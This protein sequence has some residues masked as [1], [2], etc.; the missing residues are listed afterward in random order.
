MTLAYDT[1]R[2]DD[3]TIHLQSLSVLSNLSLDA[4]DSSGKGSN[5][6]RNPAQHPDHHISAFNHIHAYIHAYIKTWQLDG[7]TGSSVMKWQDTTA[8]RPWEMDVG[9]RGL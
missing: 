4:A 5:S 9:I 6:S 8:I 7:S 3:H 1:I 2:R